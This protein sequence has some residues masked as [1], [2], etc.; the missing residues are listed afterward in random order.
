MIG[1]HQ[2]ERQWRGRLL[3]TVRWLA[4]IAVLGVL[5]H[6]LPVHLLGEAIQR[7]PITRFLLVLMGYLLAHV[8]GVAKWR[9]VVNAAGARLDY[10]TSAQCYTGGLF[11]M[12]FLPSI[13]GGDVVRLAVGLRRSPN[14]AGVLAGNVVDRFLDAASQGGLVLLGIA[15]LPGA[16]PATIQA[17][18]QKT[19]LFVGAGFAFLLFCTLLL[20]RPL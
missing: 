6:F 4:A 11:A 20:Y 8:V 1:A 7:V 9:M 18:A 2:S 15:L 14:P 10:A 5:L 12:L 16:L 19:L 17:Q 13:I 3:V